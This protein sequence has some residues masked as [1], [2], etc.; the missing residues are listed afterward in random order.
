MKKIS[1]ILIF[2]TAILPAFAQEALHLQAKLKNMPAG[3][4]IY[5]S[6]MGGAGTEDSV[7][8]IKGGF[9]FDKTIQP[10]EGGLYMIR[11][12]KAYSEGKLIQLYLDNGKVLIKGK[13]EDFKDAVFSGDSFVKDFNDFQEAVDKNP[14]LKGRKELY[15]EANRLYKEKDSVKL[16][17]LQPKLD[18]MRKITTGIQ[19]E[20]VESHL[21]SPVS[22][23]VMK[24]YLA[25][26][27]SLDEQEA[28]YEKMGPAAKQNFAGRA[29]SNSINAAKITASGQQVPDFSQADT[30]G[31]V[32]AIKD[33]RGKYVLIDFW[34]SWCVPCRHENPNVVKAFRKYYSKGFTVLGISFDQ[35]N[36]KDRWLKAIHDDELTWTHVSDLK[37]WNNAVGKIFDIRSIPANVLV[38]PKGIIIGK[39]LRGEDL[40]QKLDSIFKEK[41]LY[42]GTFTLEGESTAELNGRWLKL[43]GMDI[44]GKYHTDSAQIKEGKFSFSREIPHPVDMALVLVD[45]Q[46]DPYDQTLY[47]RFFVDPTVMHVSLHGKDISKAS[48]GG[49]YT[50]FESDAY[51]REISKIED[52]YS[53]ELQNYSDKNKQYMDASKRK[54]PQE[55]LDV[56]KNEAQEARDMLEPYFE[57][58]KDFSLNYCKEHPQ[59]FLSASMLRFLASDMN[60]QSMQEM[61]T[62]MG[63]AMQQSS[64]GVE[65]KKE[66]DKLLSGS[67]GS[68][69]TNFSGKDINGKML[70]LDDFRGKYVLLDFWASWCVPCRRGNPHLLKLYK[71][72]KP[73]GFEII[74]VSDDDRNEAAWKKAVAKDGIGVWKH[75]LRGL[76]FNNGEFDR[77]EDKS[78]AYGIHTLPTKILINPEG[79]IIGRY[80]GGGEDDAAMDRKLA[81]IFSK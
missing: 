45:K 52:R 42:G 40:D 81:E 11:I 13:G 22:S 73:K 21:L 60:L 75:V 18:E 80:G 31:K 8:S 48:V 16:A 37:Y 10:G 72:Y 54:A 19:K 61:Y 38:D 47:K 32:V 53:K 64:Y 55:E 17:A 9:R 67:P 41:P 24:F 30:S 44:T 36:G 49:G 68:M 15:A 69:A 14:A 50:E 3:K 66:M 5:I 39:N 26:D 6:E 74:G 51:E 27:L 25:Y 56:L 35:P 1:L 23:S 79:K 58:R 62:S 20:W 65:F 4:T 7:T 57:A 77:S 63:K 59:S 70:S 33:F 46:A 78:E 34:A 29:I 43:S 76:K 12:G 71:E 28:L 2:S